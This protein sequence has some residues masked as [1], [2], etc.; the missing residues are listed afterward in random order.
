MVKVRKKHL[1]MLACI[2]GLAFS[3]APYAS[4][5]AL[6][7]LGKTTKTSMKAT[8]AAAR[9]Q[10]IRS[11]S[12]AFKPVKA[13]TTTYKP[14]LVTK[15]TGQ[16]RMN[17]QRLAIQ[18]NVKKNVD[19][20]KK[21]LGI[22]GPASLRG[23]FSSNANPGLIYRRKMGNHVYIGKTKNLDRFPKRQLE[24]NRKLK[25]DMG[26]AY[27]KPSYQL[28]AGA[29]AGDARLLRVAEESA[30]RTQKRFGS[31]LTNK[32]SPMADGK[33]LSAIGR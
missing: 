8:S 31:R 22:K 6:G 23:Q 33:Y 16:L 26:A 25:K 27:K 1:I 19:L 24:H 2:S 3:S 21:N 18:S 30:Y 11:V 13:T 28:V 15:N 5:S 14:T 12:P 17:Q 4:V 20:A 29:P 7:K 32:V 10:S 9:V